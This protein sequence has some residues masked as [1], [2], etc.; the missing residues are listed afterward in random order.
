MRAFVLDHLT[1]WEDSL[2]LIEFTYD[3]SWHATIRMFQ[4]G[5][6]MVTEVDLRL[7]GIRMPTRFYLDPSLSEGQ[8][9]SLLV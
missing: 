7:V 1:S 9:Q 5:A 3:S 4:F 2:G 8:F 6:C